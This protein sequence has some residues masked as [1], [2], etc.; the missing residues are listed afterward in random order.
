MRYRCIGSS[1]LS[2]SVV[3]LGSWLTFG[4]AVPPAEATRCIDAALSIGINLFDTANVYAAGE[5]E[6][7][8]GKALAAVRDRVVIATKC[9]FPTGDE[10]H[11]RGLSRRHVLQAC[12]ES[13]RRLDV[14]TIDL[15]QCHR[16]DP[17]VPIEETAAAMSDLI[18]AGKIRFWGVS[19]W[20]AEA[21]H[22]LQNVA[23]T[24]PPISDQVRYSMLDRDVEGDVFAACRKQGFGVLAYSPLAQGV[25]TGKYRSGTLPEG[26][27]AARPETADSI[28]WR[29]RPA[30]LAKAEAIAGI[31]EEA[32]LTPAGLALAWCLRQE[33]VASVL[34]G[35]SSAAQVIENAAAAQAVISQDTLRRIEEM[36]A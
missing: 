29:L 20:P 34:T 27:R 15:Y 33:L 21:L 22:R 35:A 10:P 8:L 32:G 13:L 17:D 24:I 9:F 4:A 16:F 1:E 25:L 31:A 5:A 7:F 6:R 14:E 2:V 19:Q 36:L 12:D 30:D 28:A 3:G 26:S 18:R 23:G 11:D